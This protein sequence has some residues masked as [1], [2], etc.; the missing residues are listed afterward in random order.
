VGTI[1]LRRCFVGACEIRQLMAVWPA[2]AGNLARP[3][4]AGINEYLGFE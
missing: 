4:I 2:I 3:N 1:I